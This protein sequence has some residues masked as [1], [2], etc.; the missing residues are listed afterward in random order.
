MA[1]QFA[2]AL[3]PTLKLHLLASGAMVYIAGYLWCMLQAFGD[4]PT[5]HAQMDWAVNSLSLTNFM[6]NPNP[7]YCHGLSMQLELWRML[8]TIP[9]YRNLAIKRAA[10][11]VLILQ[12]LQQRLEGKIVWSSDEPEIITPDLWIGFLGPAVALA[13]WASGRQDALLSSSWLSSCANP[14]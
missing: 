14:K 13:L 2:L 12:L 9:R 6:I 4:D 7:T 3:V 1:K 10:Q 8:S 5:L 11:I